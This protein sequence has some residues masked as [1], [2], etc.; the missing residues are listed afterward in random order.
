MSGAFVVQQHM[1][2][3]DHD[4]TATWRL[5][6]QTLEKGAIWSIST[7]RLLCSKQCVS[8]SVTD[9]LV[10][11]LFKAGNRN[12]H[13]RG[14]I[15]HQPTSYCVKREEENK[16]KKRKIVKERREKKIGQLKEAKT[17]D[18]KLL[19]VVSMPL[20]DDSK[21]T[22]RRW[23]SAELPTSETTTETETETTTTETAAAVA[24]IVL[25]RQSLKT[26]K[27]KQ[28]RRLLRSIL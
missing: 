27:T 23:N 21:Q 16:R 25:Y 1:P 4:I 12:Q 2:R 24:R 28:M 26:K 10:I 8:Q 6:S 15:H 7:S 20:L 18:R 9:W 19:Y 11:L 5:A 17:G 22:T 14:S 13:S 3:S